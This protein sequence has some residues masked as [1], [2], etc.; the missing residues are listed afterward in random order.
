MPG[1]TLGAGDGRVS[2]CRHSPSHDSQPSE[3]QR[4]RP[5]VQCDDQVVHVGGTW[6]WGASSDPGFRTGIQR[7]RHLSLDLK[8][9][10]VR[11][12][13]AVAGR[14]EWNVGLGW[15][16]GRG[17]RPPGGGVIR[18][19]AGEVNQAPP[20]QAFINQVAVILQLQYYILLLLFLCFCSGT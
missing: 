2:E 7:K 20:G 15:Q 1:I 13:A 12:A 14:H 11:E 19:A 3:R 4:E 10:R 16:E 17:Q 9:H 5:C 18:V 8:N 6:P